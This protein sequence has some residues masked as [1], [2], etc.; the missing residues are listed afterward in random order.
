MIFIITRTILRSNLRLLDC[1]IRPKELIDKAIELGLAGIAVTDHESLGAHVELDKLQDKYRD[2]NS[3]FKI[4]R[5]NEIYLTD[6]RDTGQQYYHHI[7]IALDSLGHKMLRE[8][9]STAWMNSYYDRGMERVPTLKS[10]VEDVVRRYGQGHIY[11]STACLG[12]ELDKA[13]LELHEAEMLGNITGEKQAHDKIVTFLEWCINTYG[14]GNFSLEVQPAQSE[15]QIIVNK[16]MSSIAKA[17]GLPICITCDSHYLRKEDRYIHKAFL[18]SKEGE[19]EVDSFYEYAYLQSEEEIRRNLEGTD[20]N[21]EKLCDNSMKIWDRCEYYS[22]KRKQHVP[23]VAVPDFPKEA[24]DSHVYDTKKYPTLDKLSHSDNSQERY[25]VNYCSQEL[26]KRNLYN[27]TYLSRLEEEADIQAV[28]GEKLETCMFA[29]PIFLQHYINLFWECGST[30]GAGRGSACSGLNHWL[31]GVTQL[32]PIKNNLPYW[33]YS[34][35]DRIELGDIDIDVCP[36]KREEIFRRIREERGQLGCVQVCTYGTV[37][38]KAAVKIACRGYRSE[39]FP[40][41]IDLDEA[42]YLSSLIPSERGFVWSIS[43]CVYGNEEKERKPVNNF[44]KTVNSYPGLLD[45]LLNISGLITQRGIHASGVNFYDKD[46]YETACFMKAKNG[47]ITT[48]YSLHDAE[49]CGDVKYDFLVTEIQDVITQCINLLQEGGKIDKNL[50]LKEAYDKYLHPDVLPLQD[51]KLWEAASSG[52]ILKLFQFDTQVGGQTIKI[53]KPHTPKEMADCNSAMRLMASEKGGETPT[54]RYVRMKA[55]ISQWYDEMNRWGLSK[56]EQKILEPYYL[57]THAAPA[58]QEDMMLILMDKN[59][60]HFTLSE[61]NAA[62]KIVGKKQM[63][64]VPELHAKVLKQAPNENFGKYVWETALKPQMGYSFSLI[65]SLAYSY[66]GLQTVYLAT[67]FPIVYWNTACLRVD[68]GL[69]E[70]AATNYDKIAKAVGN[71]IARGV[72][73]RPVDINRSNYMFEPDEE[74]NSILYG[75]KSLNGVGGEVI[76]SIIQN[77]PYISLQ[78]FIDKTKSNRTVTLSLIKAGAFDQFGDRKEILADYLRQVSDPKKRLTMQNFKTLMDAY[79]LPQELDFQKRLFVFNK[80]LR[81]N[82]KVDNVYVVNYN[83]YD[84]YEQFFDID[85]LEPV[86]DTLGIDQKK[87]QKMYTKAMEPA[88]KYIQEHQQELLDALNDSL[89][90]EQWRKYAAGN[91]STWEMDSMG[92]YYHQHELANVHQ[93]WYNIVE[94][95]SLPEEPEVEYTFRRNGRDIPIYKTQRIMGTVIGKNNTKATVNLLTVDSGVVTVKFDLDYFAKYNRRIS[96]N[97]GGVNKV[98]EQGW[99]QRGTLIVVN[100]FKR[101]GML[102]AKAYKKTP[103]KQLYKITEVHQDGTMCMTHLRYGETEED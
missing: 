51:D 102:K 50:T 85:E 22:L 30:V 62:R 94:Y 32:D 65:H 76:E 15:D 82:K 44:V 55:D 70:D 79:L 3:D 38:S 9:S 77:R 69:E 92:Y 73:V 57:P 13:I 7:L 74:T 99:F 84:F 16:R 64:K 18:N 11:A 95:D 21:Y 23:Q 60:C 63:D 89:F 25:W 59:I 39:E 43:D 93:S 48:Q 28:I 78:D 19:R 56:E 37:T 98:M 96:E 91:E 8:L 103:S 33:R 49:Y 2:T 26:K 34:N 29:Y 14:E 36:S 75:M 5:G 58:Q 97:V 53:V 86:Y 88:K 1:I 20:L 90:Q 10:E 67:Y 31:L 100:G 54:E 52:K 41:G 4:V 47:A 46:P 12:S 42:E 45:I 40:T 6:T 72:S 24:V 66:I 83:Y 80:A 81:A 87:W 101:G 35:K 68:A 71:M 61:A 27:D 17:F